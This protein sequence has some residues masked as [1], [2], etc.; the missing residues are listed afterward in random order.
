MAPPFSINFEIIGIPAKFIS[1]V[2]SRK[3][4]SRIARN[5]W[6]ADCASLVRNDLFPLLSRL[7]QESLFLNHLQIS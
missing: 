3:A 5:L 7:I 6:V 2:K 1:S 4:E